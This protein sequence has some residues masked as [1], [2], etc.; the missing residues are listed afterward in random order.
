MMVMIKNMIKKKKKGS[1]K[2]KKNEIT[3]MEEEENRER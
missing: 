2:L 1:D 3:E